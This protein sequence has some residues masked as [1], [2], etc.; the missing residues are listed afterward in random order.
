MDI[1]IETMKKW[2]VFAAKTPSM[3]E[4]LTLRENVYALREELV[5]EREKSQRLK[6]KLSLKE[7]TISDGKMEW[8]KT[9]NGK[10]VPLC[11]NCLI[12]VSNE[13]TISGVDYFCTSCKGSFQ[14]VY[15][16]DI[17]KIYIQQKGYTAN[18]E[19]TIF[20]LDKEQGK[21]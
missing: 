15:C 12:Q 3:D 6:E 8:K 9:D 17:Y 10:W 1:N 5:G 2:F 19:P 11:P 13:N 18:E 7:T 21:E 20:L 4:I 16:T 14:P